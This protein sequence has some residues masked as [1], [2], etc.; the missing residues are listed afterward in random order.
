MANPKSKSDAAEQKLDDMI[1]ELDELDFWDFA[2]TGDQ[3]FWEEFFKVEDA[4]EMA[5][6]FDS[7]SFSI[8]VQ[9]NSTGE[10]KTYKNVKLKPSR[11]KIDC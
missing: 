1:A 6:E 2:D 9:N 11:R 4:L 10:T 5:D 8:T 7:P 3:A